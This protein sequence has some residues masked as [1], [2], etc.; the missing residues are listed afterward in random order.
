MFDVCC[1]GSGFSHVLIS[2]SEQSYR[3]CVPSCVGPSNINNK[4]PRPGLG[5][6]STATT[7]P[8][9]NSY[10]IVYV[11]NRNGNIFTANTEISVA[12]LSSVCSDSKIKKMK[13]EGQLHGLLNLKETNSISLRAVV[14]F[15]AL[16][17]FLSLFYFWMLIINIY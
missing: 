14:T 5:G 13:I 10:P 6:C 17:L 11:F 1:A 8:S 3:L 15:L 7:S 16:L 2:R 12:Q 4:A 9:D